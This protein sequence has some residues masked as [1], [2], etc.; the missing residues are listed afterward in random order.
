M[1]LTLQIFLIYLTA[2]LV[3]GAFSSF[4]ANEKNRN[5]LNWFLLGIVFNIIAMLA[6]IAVPAL[7][8]NKAKTKE[9][10]SYSAHNSKSNL[11][12]ETVMR[13]LLFSLGLVLILLI[14]YFNFVQ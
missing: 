5:G 9:T 3:I 11:K 6:L 10:F 4:I 13:F 1:S 14:G 2:G 12:A 7:P 8:E